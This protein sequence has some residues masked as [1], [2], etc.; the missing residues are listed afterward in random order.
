VGVEESY[1]IEKNGARCLT[2]GDR[3]II[4]VEE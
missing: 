2:G 1:V 4:L 3:E